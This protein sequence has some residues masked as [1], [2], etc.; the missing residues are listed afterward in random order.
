MAYTLD[1]GPWGVELDEPDF[2]RALGA[3]GVTLAAA[4][5]RTRLEAVVEAA[6]DP[7]ALTGILDTGEAV[8]WA[9]GRV[10]DA[11][12]ARW[13][14]AAA[15]Q[16]AAAA[17]HAWET[18][19][20]MR[21]GST[22]PRLSIVPFAD[23]L[24]PLSRLLDQLL[25]PGVGVTASVAAEGLGSRAMWSWPL[26]IGL[27]DDPPSRA[28]ASSIHPKSWPTHGHRVVDLERELRAELV[29]VPG[30]LPEVIARLT[31]LRNGVDAGCVVALGGLAGGTDLE[32][33]S[34]VGALRLR[35]RSWG[36]AA[37]D[38]APTQVDAWLDALVQRL[39]RNDTLD[40]AL[41]SV[42]GSASGWM[43][44]AD[45]AA[46]EAARLSRFGARTAS[47]LSQRRLRAG[48][49]PVS[50]P[51][52]VGLGLDD[53]GADLDVA[54]GDEGAAL[55]MAAGDEGGFA[56]ADAGAEAVAAMA[57]AVVEADR[58]QPRMA[59]ARWLQADI[60]G[61]PRFSGRPE[62][63][64]LAPDTAYGVDAW[65][66]AETT[67]IRAG[68][69]FPE[70]LL[71][72]DGR[73]H[74]LTVVFAELGGSRRTTTGHVLLPPAGS[75]TRHR[76]HFQTGS[77]GEFRA[78]VIVAYRNRVL[79]SALLRA[80]V[81]ATATRRD[82]IELTIEA[83][84]R[85]G[86]TELGGRSRFGASILHNHAQDGRPSGTLLQGSQAVPFDLD[87]VEPLVAKITADL[88]AAALDPDAYGPTLD[89][90][91][92][93]GLLFR[94]ANQGA[95]LHDELFG[96]HP[97]FKE[98]AATAERIQIVAADPNAVLPL[99]YV[100]ELPVPVAPPTLCPNARQALLDGRCSPEHHPV[101][102]Q[103]HASVVCP[104]GFWAMS[105]VIERH[106]ADP[107][108]VRRTGSAFTVDADPV[109][110]RDVLS[111]LTGAVFAASARMDRA[112]AGSSTK[113]EAALA[114]ATGRPATRVRT[115]ADWTSDVG[116]HAPSLLVLLAHSAVDDVTGLGALEIEEDQR[117]PA[118]Q[119]NEHYV[120][121]AA[122]DHPIV[123]LLGCDT[124]VPELQYQTFVTRFRMAKAALV[125]GTIATVA[126]SHAAGVAA[127]LVQ[128]LREIDASRD[129]AFGDLLREVRRRLLA[130]GEVMALALTSYGDADW[131]F[132]APGSGDAAGGGR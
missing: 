86:L 37:V 90:E 36:L 78:R 33:T 88:T 43:L 110:A 58:E 20:A 41:R 61:G 9:I 52:R 124:A 28:I 83:A 6:G 8:P 101:D 72:R 77:E 26:G 97:A 35:M 122:G 87:G 59:E 1:L 116:A 91:G 42:M 106:V 115:W 39:A 11:P 38:V 111:G 14:A 57:D 127:S 45:P 49:L 60:R 105:R 118:S 29:L 65:I 82:R 79:Q 66:G 32:V 62:R 54:A 53:E 76:F 73:K 112:V 55:E 126:G 64:R 5:P 89:A 100:Y 96:N 34:V 102:A 93:V 131:R 84:L 69:A 18:A 129:P 15:R 12:P 80:P 107:E 31:A 13:A 46:L 24:G 120:L 99:E 16:P 94:L 2:G 68:E 108:G 103:G 117:V 130:D 114:L 75:S 19:L 98:L 132:P 109:G 123:L 22:E 70:E 7:K 23:R 125:V 47:I 92:T 128:A 10:L 104:S 4:G 30:T 81:A 27:F 3:L 119:I 71:P 48:P 21:A 56:M 63:R 67:G 85:P 17:V 95:L 44:L 25:L 51:I 50:E 121:G 40:V 113:V 74:R